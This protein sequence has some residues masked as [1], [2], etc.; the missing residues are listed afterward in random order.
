MTENKKQRDLESGDNPEERKYTSGKIEKHEEQG[1]EEKD[2][3]SGDNPDE[4][5]RTKK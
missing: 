5:E 1:N 3:E 4:R 2:L